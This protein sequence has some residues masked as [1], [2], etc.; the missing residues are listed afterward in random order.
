M[1]AGNSSNIILG[2]A[3]NPDFN[4]RIRRITSVTAVTNRLVILFWLRESILDAIS[5]RSV[6]GRDASVRT[7]AGALT[8]HF[9]G[10]R[11]RSQQNPAF[12]SAGTRRRYRATTGLRAPRGMNTRSTK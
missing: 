8:R 7:D 2:C 10:Q 3:P 4:I 11:L 12:G 6:S 9:V 1:A 5:F